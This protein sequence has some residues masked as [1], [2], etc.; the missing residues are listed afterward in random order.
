MEL[1]NECH[2]QNPGSS[3]ALLI[4]LTNRLIK[5]QGI[6]NEKIERNAQFTRNMFLIYSAALAFFMQAGF[7]MICAGAVRR[8]NLQNTMLKNV[9]DA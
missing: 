7:A 4:C 9:L 5:H 8:K 1:Y 2:A 3:D 6:D